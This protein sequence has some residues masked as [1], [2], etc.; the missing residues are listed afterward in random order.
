MNLSHALLSTLTRCC[1]WLQS[2]ERLLDCSV[3][4]GFMVATLAWKDQGLVLHFWPGFFLATHGERPWGPGSSSWYYPNVQFHIT[5]SVTVALVKSTR[6]QQF[7][8]SLLPKT[9][10]MVGHCLLG[11]TGTSR[12]GSELL[13]RRRWA[14]TSSAAEGLCAQTS[15]IPFQDELSS[16]K[17]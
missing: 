6:V 8:P 10:P 2:R 11:C 12:Q 15:G 7:I 9:R 16:W 3:G 13:Q 1:H 14:Q 5:T 4:T 17:L